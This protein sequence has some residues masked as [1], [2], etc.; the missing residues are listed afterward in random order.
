M[1][2]PNFIDLFAKRATDE[3]LSAVE[4]GM[5]DPGEAAAAGLAVSTGLA[6]RAVPFLMNMAFDTFS[7]AKTEW[8]GTNISDLKKLDMSNFP[9]L[10]SPEWSKLRVKEKAKL[11]G[12]FDIKPSDPNFKG[13]IGEAGAILPELP[14]RALSVKNGKVVA[15][16]QA[17]VREAISSA[18]GLPISR[19][20]PRISSSGRIRETVLDAP[21]WFKLY[22]DDAKGVAASVD[23][24]I[25]SYK[26]SEKGVRM[27]LT[28]GPWSAMMG[29]SYNTVSK[30][31]V[32][33]WVNEA[34]IT[35][36]LGHAAHL[37]NPVAKASN[38]ARRAMFGGAMA[39]IPMAYLVGN[40]IKEMFPGEIDDKAVDFVQKHAP[41]IITATYAASELYPE[42]QASARAIKHIRNTR[43]TQAAKQALKHLVPA[44]GTYLAPLI[45]LAI[46]TSLAKKYYFDAK[47]G[48]DSLE[49]ES[50]L[51]EGFGDFWS[52]YGPLLTEPAYIATQVAKQSTDLL[53]QD[54]NTILNRVAGAARHVVKSPEFIS[55]AVGA[56][57]PAAVLAYVYHNTPHGRLTKEKWR[58]IDEKGADPI[59]RLQIAMDREEAKKKNNDITLPLITGMGAAMAGGFMRK[60][61]SDL[62]RVL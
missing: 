34:Y 5:V 37:S 28:R 15:E 55:G 19:R 50:G 47:K 60:T 29:P 30:E 39:A 23:K 24:M 53:R 35:H 62:L 11:L 18:T 17:G 21:S 49:K 58:Q 41:A 32:L 12:L 57:I 31:V 7:P 3:E 33:P 25:D 1:S 16:A 42:L 13:A 9:E 14:H 10:G 45:P 38:A 46:G 61:F 2:K 51:R 48:N 43:G 26:L 52:R 8:L 4:D 36:E 59:E 40:E 54:P 6:A 22:D 44:F 56:G 27:N 20:T